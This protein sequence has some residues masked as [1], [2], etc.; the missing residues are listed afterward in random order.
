MRNTHSASDLRNLNHTSTREFCD[1]E[2]KISSTMFAD[3]CLQYSWRRSDCDRKMH[4]KV[5]S[6]FFVHVIQDFFYIS[7]TWH[8]RLHTA[9]SEPQ[10]DRSSRSTTHSQNPSG[11]TGHSDKHVCLNSVLSGQAT[12]QASGIPPGFGVHAVGS[13][14]RRK[15]NKQ[16]HAEYQLAVAPLPMN[17]GSPSHR[18]EHI[19]LFTLQQQ[20][21]KSD[22]HEMETSN[23]SQTHAYPKERDTSTRQKERIPWQ[24]RIRDPTYCR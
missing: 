1:P 11:S 4:G 12:A 19:K 24:G 22:V 8:S 10:R 13:E 21:M 23:H 6:P 5:A 17:K 18:T 7:R 14:R 2:R 3:V 15:R 9:P 16:V 20:P